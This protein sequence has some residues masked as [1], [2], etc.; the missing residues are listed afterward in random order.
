M[1]DIPLSFLFRLF[2]AALHLHEFK[3]LFLLPPFHEFKDLFPQNSKNTFSHIFRDF[4]SN[5]FLQADRVVRSHIWSH[6]AATTV[7]MKN[8]GRHPVASEQNQI[9]GTK[10]VNNVSR[11]DKEESREQVSGGRF[12][13]VRFAN[14]IKRKRNEQR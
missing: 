8:E 3:D 2:P 4:P 9:G 5:R 10:H 14:D 1:S 13:L 12:V 7:T 6:P 11:R